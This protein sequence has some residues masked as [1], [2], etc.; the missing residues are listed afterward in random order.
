MAL[1]V[2]Y[3]LLERRNLQH[4]NGRSVAQTFAVGTFYVV[5]CFIQF[6]L[7]FDFVPMMLQKL[8][9]MLLP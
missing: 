8:V 3:M 4:E 1:L 9:M 6:I 2:L 5:D 7:V